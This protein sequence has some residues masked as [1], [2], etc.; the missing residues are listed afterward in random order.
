MSP[1]SL[2][3]SSLSLEEEPSLSEELSTQHRARVPKHP[4]TLTERRSPS[5]SLKW[6]VN[7]SVKL[8]IRANVFHP[9]PRYIALGAG[10][11]TL[12]P[13]YSRATDSTAPH[14]QIQ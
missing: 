6:R 7:P 11:S 4:K 8:W 14:R 9:R 13:R 5:I 2:S 12:G 1:L 10:N 3:S